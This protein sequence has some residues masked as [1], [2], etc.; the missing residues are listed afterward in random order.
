MSPR[1][2]CAALTLVVPAA[3]ISGCESTQ[4]RSAQLR[5]K[6]NTVLSQRTQTLITRVNPDVKVLR[7]ATLH[8]DNGSAAV[9]E[10][11]NTSR[12]A[13]VNI[14]VAIDVRGPGG[15]SVFRNDA[16]GIEPSLVGP[17]YVPPASQFAWVN[18]QVSATGVPRSVVARVG[19]GHGAPP[20]SVPSIQVGAPHLETDPTSGISAVG[21]VTDRSPIV[22]RKLV[23]YCIA[24][25]GGRIVAAGRGGIE[26]LRPNKRTRYT[27][28][29]IGNPKGAKLTVAAPPTTFA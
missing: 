17:A 25:R 1:P 29:F 11:R 12:R 22:Q 26:R 28:F 21:T 7:T 15:T 19:V 2:W 10:L 6:G 4:D 13:L 3:A 23:L 9:V 27:I 16:A 18:D 20:R 5:K 14:P 24:T 8:D